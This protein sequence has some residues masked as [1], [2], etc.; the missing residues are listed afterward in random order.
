MV[1]VR[2]VTLILFLLILAAGR[3]PAEEKKST[4]TSAPGKGSDP[5][6]SSPEEEDLSGTSCVPGELLIMVRD[7]GSGV[8]ILPFFRA[9]TEALLIEFD[10]S[11]IRYLESYEEFR[12][13]REGSLLSPQILQRADRYFRTTGL[14]RLLIVESSKPFDPSDMQ[15]A[16]SLHPAVE[17]VQANCRR[18]RSGRIRQGTSLLRKE[19]SVPPLDEFFSEQWGLTNIVND[20]DIDAL[21]A[22]RLTTG[23]PDFIIAIIDTGVDLD[24]PDLVGKFA[25]TKDF[26]VAGQSPQDVDGHGTAV[27]GTAAAWANNGPSH[28]EGIAGVCWDCSLMILRAGTDTDS[29]GQAEF[30][31]AAVL[32]AISYA[33]ING[34]NVINMSYGNS[35]IDLLEYIAIQGAID[36]RIP[37]V[38][39]SGNDGN[40]HPHYPSGYA[41]VIA[42]GATSPDDEVAALSNFGE[43][44]SIVAPGVLLPAPDEQGGYGTGRISGTSLAAPYVSGVIGLLQSVAADLSPKAIA[45]ILERSADPY[46]GISDFPAPRLPISQYVGAGRLNALNALSAVYFDDVEYDFESDNGDW[47]LPYV[48]YAFQEGVIRGFDTTPP[49]YGPAEPVTRAEAVKMAFLASGREATYP[50]GQCSGAQVFADVPLDSWYCSYASDSYAAGYALSE[51]RC[52]DSSGNVTCQEDRSRGVICFCPSRGMKRGDV[53]KVLFATFGDFNLRE[54]GDGACRGA[55]PAFLDVDAGEDYCR[56]VLWLSESVLDVSDQYPLLR[57]LPDDIDFPSPLVTGYSD[58]TFKPDRIVNRAEM[59]KFVSNVRLFCLAGPES[60]DCESQVHGLKSAGL[61]VVETPSIGRIF[62][63]ALDDTNGASPGPVMIPGGESQVVT[64]PFPFSDLDTHDADGDELFY[65]WSATDGSFAT[66]DP[67]NFSEVIWHPPSVV[68]DTTVTVRVVR[69]DRRGKVGRGTFQFLVLGSDPDSNTPASG[70]I[71]SPDGSQVGQV[72]V[73]ATVSDADNL[74]RVTVTFVSGGQELVLCGADGPVACPGASGSLTR[75]D[76]N[77]SSYGALPGPVT[78]ELFVEDSTGDKR[79]VDTHTF[80]YDP[81][82]SGG[83]YTLTVIKQGDGDGTVSGEDIT[84]GPG[85][86]STSATYNDG[87]TLTLTG[88]GDQFLGFMGDRCYGPDPCAITMYSDLTVIAAFALPD[89]FGVK[90]TYPAS[91]NTGVSTTTQPAV[92]F[93]RDIAAGPNFNSL[94]FRECDGTAL[95]FTPVLGSGTHDELLTFVLDSPMARGTCH[96]VEVPAGS[97][98]DL[99]GNPLAAPV[100]FTFTTEEDGTPQMYLSAYPTLV[101]EGRETKVSIWFDTPVDYNRT[102]TLTS[103]PSGALFHP[104]SVVLPAG[105]VLFELQVDTVLNHGSLNDVNAT[106]WVQEATAGTISENIT[107]VNDTPRFANLKFLASSISG[108]DDGDGIFESNERAD[109]LFQFYNSGSVG[110]SN[111]IVEFEVVNTYNLRILGG[112]PHTCYL[113]YL[114]PGEYASCE[115]SLLAYD[116]LPTGYYYVKVHGTGTISSGTD[117]TIEN[118]RVYVVNNDLPDFTLDAGPFT[119]Y[120]LQPGSQQTVRYTANNVGNGFDLR[121]AE[122]EVFIDIEGQEYLLHRTYADVR[123]DL[124]HSQTFDLPFTVPEVPG[125]HTIRARINP[126]GVIPESDSTNNDAAEITLNVAEPNQPPELPATIGPLVVN[127]GDSLAFTVPATDPNNDPLTYSLGPGAPSG[128]T[129]HPTTG[130]LGWTPACGTTPQ[131]YGVTVNV[132]DPDGETDSGTVFIDVRRQADLSVKKTSTFSSA[133]PGEI[134]DFTVE[135]RNGGPSCVTGATVSDVF[136]S[137][138]TQV[139]WTCAASAGSSCTAGPRSGNIA[140]SAV[141]LLSG[142]TATY[143]V[144]A[145][146][147]DTAS[148]LVSNQASVTT[149]TGV[150]DPNS[151]NNSDSTSISLRSLDFGDAGDSSLDP[152]WSY[153]TTLA[154]DGARH[155]VGALLL[156]ATVDGEADGQPTPTANGDDLAGA[157]DEEGVV[158]LDELVRCGTA[159]LEVTASA[160][161][162]LSAWIDF[163]GDGSWNEAGDAIFTDRAVAAGVNSLTVNVPCG[164][165]PGASYARFRLSS[166]GGLSVTGLALDGE[167]EDYSVLISPIRYDLSITTTGPGNGS[168]L[169]LPGGT[170]CPGTCTKTYPEGTNVNLAP[171]PAAGSAFAGWSGDCTGTGACALTM[172][173]DKTVTAT[174]EPCTYTLSQFN[175]LAPRAGLQASVDVIAPAGCPW[176]AASQASHITLSSGASGAGSSTVTFDVASNADGLHRL[177]AIE[178]AG[179]TFMVYQAGIQISAGGNHSVFLQDDGTLLA[180]GKNDRGQLADGT[181]VRRSYPAPVLDG[182]GAPLGGIAS[183]S[184]K[185]GHILFLTDDGDVLASGINTH[186][187]AGETPFTD[188]LLPGAVLDEQGLPLSGVV[189]VA[190]GEGHSVALLADGSV[191]A[192]GYGERLGDGT[193]EDRASAAPVTYEDGS[194]VREAVAIAAGYGH[195]HALLADGSVVGWGLNGGGQLADGTFVNPRPWAVPTAVQVGEVV[196]GLSPFEGGRGF[197]FARDPGSV[198]VGWGVN[199]YG[200]RGDGTTASSSVP[201]AV[202]DESGA[203]ILDAV[204]ADGGYYHGVALRQDGTLLAWGR[205]HKGQL[206]D[207][208][209]ADRHQAVEVIDEAGLAVGDVVLVSAGSYHNLALLGDGTLLAWG[210]N[211]S[212]QLGDG[213]RTDRHHPMVAN[214]A[215]AQ[216]ALTLT[217]APDPVGALTGMTLTLDVTNLGRSTATQVVLDL[218][219]D[220]LVTGASGNGWSCST[221]GTHTAQCTASSLPLG[222]AASVTVEMTVPSGSSTLTHTATVSAAE[223]DPKPADNTASETTQVFNSPPA[224]EPVGGPFTVNAGELL[225]FTVVASDPDGDDLTFSLSNAPAGASI[226]PLSGVFTWMPTDAQAGQTYSLDVMVTD[227]DPSNPLN[228]SETVQISVTRSADVSLILSDSPDPVEV[229]ATLTYTL[230]VTNQGPS[231]TTKIVVTVTLPAGVSFIDTSGCVEDPAGFPSCNLG[232]IAAGQSGQYTLTVSPSTAGEITATAC[233]TSDVPEAHPGDECATATTTVEDPDHA[234]PTVTHLDTVAGTG[235]GELSACESVRTSV[236]QVLLT[237][238]EALHDP[239]GDVDPDDVTNPDNYALLASGADQDFDTDLCAT[240]FG[241]DVPIALGAVTWDGPS[242]T[243]TLTLTEAPLADAPYRLIACGS[244]SLYDLAGNPLDGNGD[245]VGGDDF[246]MDFRVDRGN[247]FGNGHLDCG[248][249]SWLG[250]ST[251]PDEIAYSTEDVDGSSFSG[252]AHFS[253]LTASTYFALSQCVPAAEGRPHVLAARIRFTASPGVSANLSGTCEYFDGAACTGSSVGLGQG[254]QA[255]TSNGGEW[256]RFEGSWTSPSGSSSAVCTYGLTVPGSESFDAFLDDLTLQEREEIFADGFE[257]GNTSGWE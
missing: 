64:G 128:V 131:T 222:P 60:V 138:L 67:D 79:S 27:A 50:E 89:S 244:T 163:G 239:P 155:G 82:T 176:T 15:A 43:N 34:A 207:G 200:Q 202:Q 162:L 44:I 223:V 115:K 209:T 65:F 196:Q 94:A 231:G 85:C 160:S 192:W 28:T 205:N 10:I 74:E 181:T 95:G 24:H 177:G 111:P 110:I 88:T 25:D 63:Q 68:E 35:E 255:L 221:T 161:G 96:V 3:L 211:G 104:S 234:P 102:L 23:D 172:D 121:L 58:N 119:S 198:L 195:S 240:L 166:A 214:G 217:D 81:P 48:M 256:V 14:S 170:S 159:R 241:D 145:K 146:I 132:A 31:D 235:D 147:T 38:A 37:V 106:L 230:T 86:T 215:G 187:Q 62:E 174:F 108:D 171:S 70:S 87:D 203:P 156:G 16:F 193:P 249:D 175:V 158:F 21:E 188:R 72:M 22:W 168:V 66:N 208:T 83:D 210:Y 124:S 2:V 39:A 129:I 113:G 112:S 201:V 18:K 57:R 142:G 109:I 183:V 254:V 114:D 117:E 150:G 257:S 149:P 36:A 173:A 140:D 52:E 164:A 101:M 157:D 40:N 247:F 93:N 69:G 144:S 190:A 250:F 19:N 137:D 56:S 143:T 252:S 134:V 42:V 90:Y 118:A 47:F 169:I 197:G 97:I 76:V 182:T 136:A 185:S 130:L 238:N 116:D 184:T 53:A 141:N 1:G 61:V 125:S 8:P 242:R 220:A 54:D 218:E 122:F 219:T 153:P 127:I 179:K 91:G 165:V 120:P 100:S 151:A 139:T 229:D 226:D 26:L 32:E 123:G 225:S 194:P 92:S 33:T 84:C 248:L 46:I 29:D 253:N 105:Q 77:P 199:S 228:D 236:S 13:K 59:A 251:N 80:T 55:V 206:G 17:H 186:G 227:D 245:G 246:L 152:S 233:V 9:E 224:L 12:T 154:D 49:T 73:Q 30:E 103:S 243:A 20:A 167:V 216:L 148:G 212:G 133:L 98:S 99:D 232:P 71:T 178:I 107:I 7:P 78:L 191:V 4:T 51:A 180:W 5:I 45:R 75:T 126:T 41:G 213:T 135:V 204:A 11:K 237:F 189:D 6:V